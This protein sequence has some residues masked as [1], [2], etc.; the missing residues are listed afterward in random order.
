[1]SRWL[2]VLWLT[3]AV[4]ACA[5]RV[6]APAE[7]PSGGSASDT[8]AGGSI[9]PGAG[10][11]GGE[12]P[13]GG[14]GGAGGTGG[15]DAGQ[16]GDAA[17]GGTGEAAAGEDGSVGTGGVGGAPDAGGDASAVPASEWVE[18]SCHVT[19]PS[20]LVTVHSC[21]SSDDPSYVLTWYVSENVVYSCSPA[22]PVWD[23]AMP[24]PT[25]AECLVMMTG[26]SP[27]T[28]VGTC[29]PP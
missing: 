6:R 28:S 4:T 25:G 26:P 29:Q 27:S 10:G 19:R 15:Q 8:G 2:I 18:I 3:A 14:Q 13:Q 20:G 11:T 12:A 22:W 5:V 17:L 24:C 23:E 16:G 7:Q 9:S 1:M 21:T